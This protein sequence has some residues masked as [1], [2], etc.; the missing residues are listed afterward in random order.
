LIR[1]GAE[2][3][4]TEAWIFESALDMLLAY[5]QLGDDPGS[6]AEGYRL[7]WYRSRG[8][9]AGFEPKFSQNVWYPPKGGWH[10]SWEDF[11][12]R[13]NAEFRQQLSEYK[14]YVEVKFSTE[15]EE[16][17]LR[18]D[19]EWTVRYQKGESAAEIVQTI[20]IGSLDDPE[21]AV[22][23][24]IDRFAKSIGLNLRKRGVRRK[25]TSVRP[26]P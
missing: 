2:F 14:R 3:N 26:R 5:F 23:R 15:K 1:W 18:R 10:E 22:F 9:H 24:A 20:D 7:W 16:H 6:D 13:M 21:Q 25:R 12:S 19:A 8:F 17:L 11:R 4:I